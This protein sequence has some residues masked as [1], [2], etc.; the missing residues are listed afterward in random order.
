MAPSW[1]WILVVCL[2]AT[3]TCGIASARKHIHSEDEPPPL[4]EAEGLD[5]YAEGQDVEESTD[6]TRVDERVEEYGEDEQEELEYDPTFDG[7]TSD[8]QEDENAADEYQVEYDGEGNVDEMPENGYDGEVEDEEEDAFGTI[9]AEAE[10]KEYEEEEVAEQEEENEDLEYDP[11]FEEHEDLPNDYEY[12]SEDQ[13]RP[14]VTDA[15]QM[16]ILSAIGGRKRDEGL[17][18]VLRVGESL[19]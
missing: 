12:T 4:D 10:E 15:C 19:A 11:T 1:R 16:S 9:L 2:L 17:Y 18:P 5:K 14:P 3:T 13:V 6:V 7:K 8:E